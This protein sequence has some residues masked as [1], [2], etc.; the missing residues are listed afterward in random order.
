M[1]VHVTSDLHFNHGNVI[2]FCDRPFTD[3]AE[4]NAA[5]I[6]R[7]NRA[8]SHSDD[9]YV[10]GDFCFAPN[11]GADKASSIF[12]RLNGRKHLVVG[13]HDEQNPGVINNLPWTS[14]SWLSN[15][16]LEGKYYV[17]CHYAIESWWHRGKGV[18]HLHGHSHGTLV[19]DTPNRWDVGVDVDYSAHGFERYS[20]LPLQFFADHAVAVNDY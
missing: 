16:K 9:T 8:V 3:A 19:T 6:E 18:V 7:W 13:N 15:I 12:H 20:P 1:T 11:T 5:L 2:K 14:V 10:L 17:L 4:M